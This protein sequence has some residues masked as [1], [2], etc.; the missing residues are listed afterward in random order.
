MECFSKLDVTM[1]LSDHETIK[2]AQS[3]H[4][5]PKSVSLRLQYFNTY[6]DYHFH[7]FHVKIYIYSKFSFKSWLFNIFAM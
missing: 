1:K 4:R 5:K 3:W 6:V 2:Y 7:I